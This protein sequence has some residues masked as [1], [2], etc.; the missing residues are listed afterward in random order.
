MNLQ[1]IL[2][3]LLAEGKVTQTDIGSI[4]TAVTKITQTK[5]TKAT[6]TLNRRIKDLETTNEQLQTE[7]NDSKNSKTDVTSLEQELSE[8]D[9]VIAELNAQLTPYK[10]KERETDIFGKLKELDPEGD[11]ESHYYT[12]KGKGLFNDE[13]DTEDIIKIYSEQYTKENK[14]EQ[15]GNV[16]PIKTGENTSETKVPNDYIPFA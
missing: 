4:N 3:G 16:P 5:V 1:E 7:V 13:T 12:L 14:T 8:K 10:T 11:I 9:K 6:T 2:D 15:K